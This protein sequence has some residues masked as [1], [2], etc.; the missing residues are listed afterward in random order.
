MDEARRMASYIAAQNLPAGSRIG[1][2]SKNCAHFI[3]SDLA[4]WMA[5]HVSVAL[6]PTLAADTVGYCLQHSDVKLLF[7]GK[8]DGWDGM[9]PGVPAGLPCVSYP[10]SPP[11]DF[12]TWDKLIKEHE[13]LVGNPTR[14]AGDLAIIVYTSGSTGQ[15]KGV[16]H[17]FG[18]MSVA[19]SNFV[20]MFNVNQSDRF[21]SYLPLAHVFE[22]AAIECL[23]IFSGGQVFFADSLDTFVEDLKRARPTLFQ[24]VPRLWL[25]FQLGVFSKMPPKKL[26]LFLKIPILNGIVRKKVLTGPRPARHAHRH[27]RVRPHSA[28]AGGVVPQPGPRAARGLRH[29][30]ELLLLAHGATW[31]RAPRL[32][33]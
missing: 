31:P 6:Y 17:S 25:K 2:L 32:R 18:T 16:M 33:G 27:Q 29:E 9:K 20:K 14:P 24:S 4:I 26:G 15:P 7:V 30:R 12:P 28:R 11:N 3:M 19:A 23:S 13:P 21:I 10:L 5:G 8:L 1:I 22:R